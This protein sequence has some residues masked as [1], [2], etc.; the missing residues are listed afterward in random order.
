MNITSRCHVPALFLVS[1]GEFR[2][3]APAKLV[4]MPDIKR[5]N[6]VEL[7]HL[8]LC[9]EIKQ[10]PHFNVCKLCILIIYLKIFHDLHKKAGLWYEAI[11]NAF[12]SCSPPSNY[13]PLIYPL[14]YQYDRAWFHWCG[15]H[16]WKAWFTS[17]GGVTQ[18]KGWL[19][20]KWKLS[21]ILGTH[22]HLATQL[23]KLG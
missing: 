15:A 11:I 1:L 12:S 6:Q 17:H 20:Q 16:S 8:S 18:S 10:S 4:R 22:L 21:D 3:D 23:S 5:K 19:C 13:F 14:I 9:K 7:L 2:C